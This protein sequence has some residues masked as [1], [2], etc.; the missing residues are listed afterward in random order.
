MLVSQI[1]QDMRSI[2]RIRHYDFMGYNIRNVSDLSYH[3]IKKD[4]DGGPKTIENGA[5]L[6]KNTAH[7]YL[8]VIEDRDLDMYIYIN[9]I[10]K[11]INEQK[12][13]P[14]KAQLIAI[15]NV[16]LQF[17]DEHRKEVNTAGKLLIKQR[18]IKERV[19]Y[20]TLWRDKANESFLWKVR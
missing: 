7:P 17:E 9:K 20:D 16:L 10:L 6:A 11:I 1:I 14:T 8:H 12:S 13:P 5:L 19:D 3:H 18:Y 15:R 4:C 2:Y